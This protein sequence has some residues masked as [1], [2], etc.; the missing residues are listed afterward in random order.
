[1]DGAALVFSEMV[2]AELV[3]DVAIYNSLIKGRCQAGKVGEAWKF[4]DLTRF[5]R[6]CNTTTYNLMMKGLLDSGM[7]DEATELL[8]QLENEACSPPTR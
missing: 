2:K 3:L 8:V 7:V 4:W 1:V 6:I 5:S